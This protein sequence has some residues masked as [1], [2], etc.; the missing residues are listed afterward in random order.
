MSERKTIQINPAFLSTN[1]IKNT[2][3]KN[4]IKREKRETPVTTFKPNYIKKQL[5]QR[6][7]NKQKEVEDTIVEDTMA[8]NTEPEDKDFNDEF[9][10]SLGFLQDLATKQ[11]HREIRNKTLKNP[12]SFLN[13]NTELPNDFDIPLSEVP[14][15]VQSFNVPTA[16]VVTPLIQKKTNTFTLKSRPP[17]GNLKMGT[18]PTYRQW[19]NTISH[20]PNI[21]PL[22]SIRIEDKPEIQETHRSRELEQLKQQYKAAQTQVPA[23]QAPAPQVPAPKDKQYKK[24]RRITKTFRYKLGKTGDKVSVL[25]KNN[26]SRKKVQHEHALLKKKTIMEIKNYLREKNLLKTGSDAPNDVL[27]QMYEQSILSGDLNNTS[28][29]TLIHNF[30]HN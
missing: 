18:V 14:D 23:A 22:P 4:N 2:T 9:N 24:F 13:V 8:E 17:Y 12:K 11:Q 27:R 19:K 26:N 29:N 25:I 3:L 28:K 30:L 1:K 10:K 16:E 15:I 20:K 21:E 5:L 7:K 6:I